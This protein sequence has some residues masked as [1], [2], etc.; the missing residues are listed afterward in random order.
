ML[1]RRHILAGGAA[2]FALP[3]VVQAAA[4]LRVTQRLVVLGDSYSDPN[5]TAFPNWTELLVSR[6]RAATT[7]NLALAGATA[8]SYVGAASR[9]TFKS[10]LDIFLANPGWGPDDVTIVYFGYNDIARS[11]NAGWTTLTQSKIDYRTGVDRLIAA[12]A[13]SGKRRLVLTAVHDWSKNPKTRAEYVTRTRDWLTFTFDLISKRKGV[14]NANIFRRLT[15]VYLRPQA[16]GLNNVT[17]VDTARS[18]TTALYWNNNHFGAKGH[19]ILA[20]EFGR[21]LDFVAR[22]R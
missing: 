9:A 16:Y 21:V 5:F 3:S 6:G 17:T 2:A 19:Q 8:K 7:R 13:T 1:S 11:T 20:D 15:D 12:G 22:T 18:A 14:I 4:P 10:Q